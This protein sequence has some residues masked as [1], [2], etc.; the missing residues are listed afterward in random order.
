MFG[1]GLVFS[2]FLGRTGWGTLFL[3][4]LTAALLAGSAALPKSIDAQ[5]VRTDWAPAVA[6]EV[7]PGYRLGTGDATLDLSRITVPAG[8][9]LTTGAELGAGRARVVVPKDVTVKM[10]L[11]LGVA[12]VRLP[13]EGPDDMRVA[14]HQKPDPHAGP[15]RRCETRGD[16]GAAA[17]GRRR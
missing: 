6:G 1:L 10:S 14:T 12:G 11:D 5:W 7:R 3:A 16:L 9:T 4:V 2:S 15:A 13:G 17:Q 8:K